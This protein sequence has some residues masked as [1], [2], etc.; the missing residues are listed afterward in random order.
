MVL[1]VTGGHGG[2]G[3]TDMAGMAD[4]AGGHDG[5]WLSLA[6]AAVALGYSERTIRR[7]L[8]TGRYQKRRAHGRM[9]VLVP[10]AAMADNGI[11]ALAEPA[12]TADTMD[13]RAGGLSDRADMPDT[14]AATHALGA[15]E[16]VLAEERSRADRERERASAAEQ[17][18]AMWQERA[19]NL[20]GE[21]QRVLALPAHEEPDLRRHWWQ[22]RRG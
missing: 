18:A 10:S 3:T 11:T 1:S 5:R 14:V 13:M 2:E 20:E 16:R 17:A 19:R 22:W 6:E 8:A 9:Q 15:L 12:D 4:L 7:A 21:L